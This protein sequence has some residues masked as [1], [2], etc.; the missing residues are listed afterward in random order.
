MPKEKPGPL[1]PGL[2][3]LQI[4]V[5]A[6]ATFFDDSGSRR[7]D[8]PFHKTFGGSSDNAVRIHTD[9]KYCARSCDT[10]TEIDYA[11]TNAEIPGSA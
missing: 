9:R 10:R 3:S 11:N 8:G 5:Y 4:N 7:R 6:S 2:K 1:S